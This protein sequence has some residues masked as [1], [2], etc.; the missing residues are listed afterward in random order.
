M[1]RVFCVIRVSVS[2]HRHDHI[3]AVGKNVRRDRHRFADGALDGKP[4]VVHFRRNALDDDA[5]AERFRNVR[6]NR[7]PVDW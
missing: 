1:F 2:K 6:R 7:L 5:C 4:P 3:M